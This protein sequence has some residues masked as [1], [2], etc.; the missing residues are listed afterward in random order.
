MFGRK[1][2]IQPNSNWRELEK[3]QAREIA[4]RNPESNVSTQKVYRGYEKRPDVYGQHK[5]IP[6]KRIGG[7]AKCVKVLTSNNVKQAKSYKKH[8]GYLSNMEVGVCKD[9]RVPHKI[10]KEIRDSGMTLKRYDVSREKPWYK[11]I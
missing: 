4:K 7:E 9:S 3:V 11:R 1:K 10:R 5:T 8:P 2:G 6:H